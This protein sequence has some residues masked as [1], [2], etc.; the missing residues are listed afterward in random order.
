MSNPTNVIHP[1]FYQAEAERWKRAAEAKERLAAD[2]NITIAEQ[3]DEMK[4]RE[5]QA[6]LANTLMLAVMLRQNPDAASFLMTITPEE[7]VA[8]GRYDAEVRRQED[9]GFTVKVDAIDTATEPA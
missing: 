3:R 8:A 5:A 7:L 9:G 4:I 1:T 6:A 2:R